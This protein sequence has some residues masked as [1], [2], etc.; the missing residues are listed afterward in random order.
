MTSHD[1]TESGFL[2]PADAWEPLEAMMTDVEILHV[3]TDSV[4]ARGRRYGRLWLLK[5]LRPELRHSTPHIRRLMKEFALHSRLLHRGVASAVAVEEVE[6]LGP[7][8]VMEWIEGVTLGEYLAGKVTA[9]ERRRVIRETVEA[10]A[11]IHAQGIV[12]RDLK[13]DNIMIT[14]NGRHPVVIDFGLADDDSY[15]VLKQPAGTVGYMAEE[16]M[17]EARP[18]AANDVYSLGVIISAF[19][20]PYAAIAQRCMAPV[21]KRYDNA[22]QLLEAIDRQGRRVSRL[23]AATVAAVILLLTG[24]SAWLALRSAGEVDELRRTAA[25]YR[26]ETVLLHDSLVEVR[27]D[28][29]ATTGLLASESA[30]REAIEARQTMI[31][32]AVSRGKRLIDKTLADYLAHRL[33]QLDLN[34]FNDLSTLNYELTMK[35]REAADKAK[36]SYCAGLDETDAVMVGSAIDNYSMI[37]MSKWQKKYVFPNLTAH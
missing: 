31:D 1:N 36:S 23:K 17:A 4:I 7:C 34:N 29:A 24:M 5:G 35:T 18:R 13:P 10:V 3:K 8:I 33:P 28:L 16:Q 27:A 37:E 6:G 21:G 26:A 19:C 11:Y 30:R 15:T 12:H 32:E 9:G 22:R 25:G 20:R 14:D 2:G